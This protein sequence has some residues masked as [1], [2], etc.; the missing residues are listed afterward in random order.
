MSFYREAMFYKKLD[1]DVVSC[2][3]CPHHC[4]LQEGQTGLCRARINEAGSLLSLNYGQVSSLGLDPIEK[5]PLYHFYP[6]KT[7]LSVGSFGC[8]FACSFCQNYSIAQQIPEVQYI[9][10]HALLDLAKRYAKAGSIGIAFTYNEPSIWYEY[11]MEL[12]PRLQEQGLKTVLVS[13]GFIEKKALQQILPYIDAVNIDV[14]SFNDEFYRKFCHG[15]LGTV[16]ENIETMISQT[17]VEITTLIIPGENDQEEEMRKLSKWLAALDQQTALHLSRYY[18]AYKMNLPPTPEA[19]LRRCRDIAREALS[20][21]YIGN[22]PGETND[23]HC[24]QCGNVL[25]HRN[26]YEI[27]ITGIEEGCC[28]QCGAEI[29]FIMGW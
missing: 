2:S 28:K 15:N 23:T 20:F 5:K 25:I 9:A 3:L 21:V 29:G 7:I 12:A 1:H 10:P 8:N 16:K 13:N 22:L 14:K 18:P 24:L 11:I 19:T 27:Q 6:E 4:T 26:A 17:H